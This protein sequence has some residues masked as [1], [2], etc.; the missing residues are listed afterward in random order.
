MYTSPKIRYQVST[1]AKYDSFKANEF[2]SVIYKLD[3][4]YALYR[5]FNL[6][7]AHSIFIVVK[8]LSFANVG[9]NHNKN[10]RGFC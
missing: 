5:N 10:V 8:D 2:L 3:L 7:C 9:T 4:S 1:I 6:G